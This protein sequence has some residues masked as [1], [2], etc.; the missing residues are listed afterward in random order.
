M[1]MHT[2]P[3][4]NHLLAALGTVEWHRLQPHA[5]RVWLTRGQVLCD[6]GETMSHA[7]FPTTALSS[8]TSVTLD[9]GGTESAVV[10]NDGMLG[11]WLFMGGGHACGCASVLTTGEAFRVPAQVL[12]DEFHRGGPTMQ[13]LLRYTQALMTQMAQRIACTRHH[14]IAQQVAVCLLQQADRSSND[15]VFMTHEQLALR[16][17]VRREGVTEGAHLLHKLGLIRYARGR[18]EI[19]NRPELEEHACE[20]YDVLAQEY[21]RLL[22]PPGCNP[23]MLHAA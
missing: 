10:G 17:G 12:K 3:A 19:V 4:E 23:Y 13:I 6:S 9:G 18:V 14:K 1:Q 21:K 22:P 2:S 5:E 11:V 8:L 7:Y 16:L 15:E 20:C